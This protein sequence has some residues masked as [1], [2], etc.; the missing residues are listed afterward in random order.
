[1]TGSEEAGASNSAPGRWDGGGASDSG[2]LTAQSRETVIL[3]KADPWPRLCYLGSLLEDQVRSP[4]V[5]Q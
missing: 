5:V 1:M 2:A 4:S 3:M